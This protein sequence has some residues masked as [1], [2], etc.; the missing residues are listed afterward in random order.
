MGDG[1]LAYFGYPQAHEGDPERA[2]RAGLELIEAIAALA[3]R[4][5]LR[6]EARIGIATGLVVVGDLIGDGSA[7][8]QAVVGETPNLAA[9]LQALAQARRR[10]HQPATR[11]LI[12]RSTARSWASTSSRASPVRSSLT[13]VLAPRRVGR[14]EA[15][16]AT[17]LAPMVGRE[18]EI[19][20]LGERWQQA[21]DHGE[22]RVAIL[23]GEP[24]IGKSRIV[25]ALE[26]RLAGERRERSATSAC[27][28]IATARCRS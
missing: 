17:S 10:R 9:R 13:R 4:P 28:T 19:A 20:L 5:D 27:P 7:K 22:G 15:L 23:A 12:G 25:L 6:L 24:G 18:Q 8:E 21:R 2:V 1:V 3:P 16:R 14:F 11:R 26:E